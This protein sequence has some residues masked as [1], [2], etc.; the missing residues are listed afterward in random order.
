MV[1][2]LPILVLNTAIKIYGV[3]FNFNLS[4]TWKIS[5]DI[6]IMEVTSSTAQANKAEC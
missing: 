4:Q 5:V 1:P 6:K 2:A 3:G